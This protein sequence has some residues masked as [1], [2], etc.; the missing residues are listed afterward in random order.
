MRSRP[1]PDRNLSNPI[2]D[3]PSVPLSVYRELA[4]QL[5]A[6]EALSNALNA[7]NQH[8]LRQNQQLQQ[9]F[10]KAVESALYWRRQA[11]NAQKTA[12]RSFPVANHSLPKSPLSKTPVAKE[13]LP[14]RVKQTNSP[15]P[16]IIEQEQGRYR[17]HLPKTIAETRGWSLAIAIL[18]IM[19]TA[20]GAGYF[21]MRPLVPRR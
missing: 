18:L 19:L 7:Q 21:M 6:A 20:F 11:I 2:A 13:T 10:E 17:R 15:S 16:Q 3:A 9:E 1:T 4:A 8:L 12:H 14:W 5:Q